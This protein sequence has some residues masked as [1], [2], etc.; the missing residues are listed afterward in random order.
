MMVVLPL[1]ALYAVFLLWYGGRG[2]PM[3]RDYGGSGSAARGDRAAARLNAD[4]ALQLSGSAHSTSGKLSAT[5]HA[6]ASAFAT[7][8]TAGCPV[9]AKAQRL[10]SP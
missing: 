7:A 5:N 6:K 3:R 4:P 9:R 1:V 2:K 8:A 10:N